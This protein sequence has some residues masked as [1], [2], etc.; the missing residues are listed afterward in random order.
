MCWGGDKWVRSSKPAALTADR[1]ARR[2]GSLPRVPGYAFSQGLPLASSDLDRNGTA[3]LIA[4]TIQ[5]NIWSQFFTEHFGF[6]LTL[7]CHG[8]SCP[9]YNKGNYSLGPG[10]LGSHLPPHDLPWQLGSC[11]V[12]ALAILIFQWLFCSKRPLRVQRHPEFRRLPSEWDMG[13]LLLPIRGGG[14]GRGVHS[15]HLSVFCL[16]K[17]TDLCA[18]Y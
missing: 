5:L 10:C 17:E 13:C 1:R 11:G 8:K 7:G 9:Y 18:F 15:N 14:V 6:L 2:P 3:L 16:W 12:L 4:A